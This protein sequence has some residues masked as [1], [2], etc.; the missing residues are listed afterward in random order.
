MNPLETL[1]NRHPWPERRPDV[2]ED[3]HGW[4]HPQTAELLNRYLSPQI[5]VVVELG[6]WLGYSA[7]HVLRRAPRATVICVDHWQGGPEHRANPDWSRRLPTLYDTF[8]RNLWPWR[9]R[10]IP[11]RADTLA[12]LKEIRL[13]GVTPDLVYVDATHTYQRVRREIDVSSEAW[14]NAVLVG[15]D[16][17][18]SAVKQAAD[19]CAVRLERN[20]ISTQTAWAIEPA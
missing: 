19:D 20:L 6:S 10:L 17:N 2:P 9:N 3:W 11:I 5:R 16:Y 7:R 13:V 14:P 18:N 4:M 12:G 8:L 1:R 15:D